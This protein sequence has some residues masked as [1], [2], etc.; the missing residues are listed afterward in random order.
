MLPR[1]GEIWVVNL[2]PQVGAEI[3]KKRPVIVVSLNELER[4][5]LRIIVPC[6]TSARAA[7]WMVSITATDENNL[8]RD[9]TA[10]CD[11]VK[12]ISTDRFIHRIG[13]VDDSVL[14]EIVAGIVLCVGYT[15]KYADQ[16][17][18]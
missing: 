1:R 6:S 3:Q 11:Q 18:R 17:K 4:L 8:D 16:D 2:D 12:S 15:P 10:L 13:H 5:P 9:T 14:K 7:P